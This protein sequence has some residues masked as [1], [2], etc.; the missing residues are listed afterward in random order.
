[1]LTVSEILALFVRKIA[2]VVADDDLDSPTHIGIFGGLAVVIVAA[3]AA[4]VLILGD[5]DQHCKE[6]PKDDEAK[7]AHAVQKQRL[8]P[9]SPSPADHR[10]SHRWR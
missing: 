9:A 8:P 5:Q 4:D 10:A 2:I 1:M 6:A 3:A 7:R